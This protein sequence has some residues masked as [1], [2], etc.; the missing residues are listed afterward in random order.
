MS[1][2]T[3]SAPPVLLERDGDVLVVKLN[4]PRCYNAINA[5]LLAGLK[6]AWQ[7][8][9]APEVR[10][11]V[12]TGNGRGFCAGADLKSP[13]GQTQGP[14][15]LEHGYNPHVL[16]LVSLRKAVVCAV[17]GPAAGSGLA[18]AC[19]GDIRIAADNAVFASGFARIGL[20][21]DAGTSFLLPRLI[22]YSRAFDFLCS[23]ETID[24]RRAL[25]WGLVNDVVPAD[26]LLSCALERAH[27]FAD[28]PGAAVEMT[29]QLLTRAHGGTL[30]ELLDEEARW[31]PVVIDHP[32]RAAARAEV[33]ARLSAGSSVDTPCPPAN[34]G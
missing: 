31:Q 34:G 7:F 15:G 21:P 17:N 16:S 5:E 9:A 22:G 13:P 8:A 10:A 14:T 2:H 20:I 1:G 28:M 3:E 23:G 29:K 24:A 33:V 19:S 26:K 32:S 11:V 12:V 30:P 18:L 6:E 4:R 25:E 27:G